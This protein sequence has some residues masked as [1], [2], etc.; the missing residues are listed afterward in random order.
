MDVNVVSRRDRNAGAADDLTIATNHSSR[1]HSMTRDLMT[2]WDVGARGD[3]QA[4]GSLAFGNV[5]QGDGDVV[6]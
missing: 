5:I 2:R 6:E 1:F 3:V 4:F